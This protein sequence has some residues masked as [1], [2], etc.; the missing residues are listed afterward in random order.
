MEDFMVIRKRTAKDIPARFQMEVK[1]EELDEMERLCKMG[2]ISSKKELLNTALTL[3]KWGVREKQRGNSIASIDENG[4]V[5]SEPYMHYLESV[6][7]DAGR[8]L[9][10]I[11]PRTTDPNNNINSD[12]MGDRTHDVPEDERSEVSVAALG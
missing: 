12:V 8:H 1:R 9:R 5:Q 6:G 7:I 3:L 4:Q 2:G 11:H 10:M